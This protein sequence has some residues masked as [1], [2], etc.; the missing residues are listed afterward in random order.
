MC[1]CVCVCV[2]LVSFAIGVYAFVRSCASL[3]V[4]DFLCIDFCVCVC[5]CVNLFIDLISC[6]MP[7][8]MG[9]LSWVALRYVY[10]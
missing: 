8:M 1:V 9:A 2:V 5:V 4:C 3:Y 10:L 6:S 7:L